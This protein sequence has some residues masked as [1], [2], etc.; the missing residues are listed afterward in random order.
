MANRVVIVLLTCFWVMGS[1][2][3]S[4]PPEVEEP[5]PD[6]LWK[7]ELEKLTFTKGVPVS[8][9]GKILVKYQTDTVWYPEIKIK[10]KNQLLTSPVA[11]VSD[12]Y[13]VD[14]NGFICYR[15]SL[16]L[17]EFMRLNVGLPFHYHW[18]LLELGDIKTQLKT[19]QILEA[20]SP[21]GKDVIK[22]SIVWYEVKGSSI[23]RFLKARANRGE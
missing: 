12:K 5:K 23:S 15:F 4:A 18:S 14:K 3:T 2:L 1:T 9:A 8:V 22:F 13:A 21:D 11:G 17:E 20:K 16:N 7:V 19:K 6:I 10:T